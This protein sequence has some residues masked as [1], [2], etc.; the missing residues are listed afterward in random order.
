MVDIKR[1]GNIPTCTVSS[2]FGAGAGSEEGVVHTHKSKTRSTYNGSKGHV[3]GDAAPR[4]AQKACCVD[5]CPEDKGHQRLFNR[6][7]TIPSVLFHHHGTD[8]KSQASKAGNQLGIVAALWQAMSPQ[9][10]N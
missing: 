1:I 4:A 3:L 2:K 9:S 7:G 6:V 8:R 5:P 10:L